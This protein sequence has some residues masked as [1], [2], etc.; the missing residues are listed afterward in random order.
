MEGE[1][2]GVPEVKFVRLRTGA[3]RSSGMR[4][5]ARR[6][7]TIMVKADYDAQSGYVGNMVVV[8]E[9]A[10]PGWQAE[11]T[12]NILINEDFGAYAV[13][14][15]DW[16]DEGNDRILYGKGLYAGGYSR[17]KALY[18]V[19]YGVIAVAADGTSM[20]SN[21]YDQAQI[22]AQLLIWRQF[23]KATMISQTARTAYG[24]TVHRWI[25]MCNGVTS[26][27]IIDYDFDQAQGGDRNLGRSMK[28]KVMS[29][30]K[31]K[32]VNLVKIPYKDRRERL[33]QES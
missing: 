9:T 1:L 14:E 18:D 23:T 4:W 16:L 27:R 12:D 22:A 11:T 8:A 3:R 32:E 29:D 28:M 15:D 30:L 26:Q 33:L 17:S 31:L 2:A 13:S 10:E 19:Q 5:Q 6:K 7:S 21:F 20:V 24:C 25:V